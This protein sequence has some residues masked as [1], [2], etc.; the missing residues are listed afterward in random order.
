MSRKRVV[1]LLLAA[2]AVAGGSVIVAGSAFAGGLHHKRQHH[3][4]RTARFAV[5]T[6]GTRTPIKHVVVI[7]Q[8]NVSFDHYFGTYPERRQHRR[9]DL[10]CG[11]RYARRRRAAARDELDAAAEPAAHGQPA[12]EQPERRAAGAARLERDRRVGQSGRPAHVRSGPQLQRRA[13]GVRQR[14]DGPASSRASA[15][16]GPRRAR[17]GRSATRTS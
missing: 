11:A 10:Q 4:T 6:S 9:P 14:Q 3:R 17:S 13:A 5:M 12:H 7:F 16:A 15:P 2:L 8:E 1:P